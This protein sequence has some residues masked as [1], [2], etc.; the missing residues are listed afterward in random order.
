MM[1]TGLGENSNCLT[2]D[3][4]E[5][6]PTSDSCSLGAL[7]DFL[8]EGFFEALF[9]QFKMSFEHAYRAALGADM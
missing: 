9:L 1:D 5:P 3:G 7:G 4:E 8:V 2:T 6:S